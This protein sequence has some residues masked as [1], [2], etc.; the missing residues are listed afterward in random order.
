MKNVLTLS[1]SFRFALLAA[2]CA[3]QISGTVIAM[4]HTQTLD[5][6]DKQLFQAVI[7]NRLD[8]IE[9]LLKQGAD[10]NMRDTSGSTPLHWACRNGQLEIARLLV[11]KGADVNA[12][13]DDGKTPLHLA[14]LRFIDSSKEDLKAQRASS[15]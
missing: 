5:D 4:E 6:K 11:K 3:L 15:L 7:N 12:Q 10:P 14:I 13:R 8:R 1:R 2:A 9:Q